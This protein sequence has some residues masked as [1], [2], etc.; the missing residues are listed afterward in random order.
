MYSSL[1]TGKKQKNIKDKIFNLLFLHYMKN[2]MFIYESNTHHY[3]INH[4]AALCL[5]A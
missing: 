3:T 5:R 4:F 1:I 2:D